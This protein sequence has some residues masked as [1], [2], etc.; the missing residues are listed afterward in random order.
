MA[1]QRRIV[2]GH[3]SRSF[4][5]VS[6]PARVWL[7]GKPVPPFSAL[8]FLAAAPPA[9]SLCVSHF[10]F[11]SPISSLY[12]FVGEYLRLHIMP[13]AALLASLASSRRV[14]FFSLIS[15]ALRC[16]VSYL[17]ICHDSAQIASG[18]ICLSGLGYARCFAFAD[19]S[20]ALD[21]NPTLFKSVCRSNHTAR[22]LFIHKTRVDFLVPLV[23]RM[24]LYL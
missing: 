19:V 11:A 13:P 5:Y 14:S 8:M 3:F 20:N 10:A 7:S 21:T 9:L 24:Y 2:A 6:I 23:H 1:C 18:T 4:F 22:H 12:L 15:L 16:L 17:M